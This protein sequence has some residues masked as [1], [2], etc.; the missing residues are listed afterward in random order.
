MQNRRDFLLHSAAGLTL[1]AVGGS[2][3]QA[4]EPEYVVKLATVAPAGTP[5]ARQLR[6]LKKAI[7][8]VEVETEGKD[9]KDKL[10]GYKRDKVELSLDITAGREHVVSDLRVRLTELE[11]TSSGLRL[12]LSLPMNIS[13]ANAAGLDAAAR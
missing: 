7:K 13:A 5:W 10:S 11:E 6:K 3:A 12:W 8:E 1:L 2:S 4:E 9:G